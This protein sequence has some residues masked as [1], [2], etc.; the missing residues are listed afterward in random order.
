MLKYPFGDNEDDYSIIAK[1][2]A[3]PAVGEFGTIVYHHRAAFESLA[4]AG[5][6]Y[7]PVDTLE[8]AEFWLNEFSTKTI[9]IAGI[10]NI[11]YSNVYFL[12]AEAVP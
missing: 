3:L 2:N 5:T 7:Y 8:E 4:Q 6:L 1:R 12:P 10:S 9:T 11:L